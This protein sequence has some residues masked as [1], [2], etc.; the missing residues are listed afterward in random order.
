[1]QFVVA[2]NFVVI[3]GLIAVTFLLFQINAKLEKMIES[4]SSL[5]PKD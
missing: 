4:G 5:K 3:V 2:L 1:M